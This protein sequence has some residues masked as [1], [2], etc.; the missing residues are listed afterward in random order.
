MVE[1]FY[2]VRDSLGGRK[3]QVEERDDMIC[4]VL[5]ERVVEEFFFREFGL[6]ALKESLKNKQFPQQ[7]AILKDFYNPL[8]R[9]LGK[10]LRDI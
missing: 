3:E 9:K 4:E 5:T 6:E 8:H 7:C 10:V 2:E 1:Y